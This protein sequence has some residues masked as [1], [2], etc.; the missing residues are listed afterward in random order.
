V[1]LWT[2]NH[3]LMGPL[4]LASSISNATAA[5]ALILALARGDHAALKR[6]ER[7]DS[8]ALLAELGLLLLFRARLG[9][10]IGRPLDEGR[11]GWLHRAGVLGLGIAAPLALQAPT[12]FLRGHPSR[13]LT[14]L[15]SLLVLGGGFLFRYVIIM[16][17]RAS[18]DDPQATFELTRAPDAR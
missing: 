4:F 18:A 13:P 11:L 9:P 5:I 15:A 17:G 8:L 12:A 1:P 7:L 10:V 16:A 14:A 2:K 6:L 3:L